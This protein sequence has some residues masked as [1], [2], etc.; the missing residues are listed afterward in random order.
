MYN[1]SGALVGS[2]TG[3]GNS[4]TVSLAGLAAGTYYVRVYGYLGATNPSYSLG[5]S[6]PAATTSPP[7]TTPTSPATSF[8]DV[9]YFGGSNDWNLNAI[10]APEAWAQG[11][12]G[13]GV[14]VAV[15]DTGV[16][17][18]NSD[19]AG[20]MWVNAGEI[21]GNGIDDDQNGFVDDT[22][23]WDFASGDNNPNDGNGHGTHVAGT[24]AA[25]NN[26]TG[27]TGVAPGATI[28]PV[29]V[30]GSNGSG[31][32]DAVAAGIRY[33]AA[34]GADIINLSLGGSFSSVIQSAIQY[35]QQLN[36]LV[37]VAAGN[38]SASTPSY[39]ARFSASMNNVIS[40]GAHTS[41]NTIAS[42]SNDVGSSGAVQVDAPGVN[43][44]STYIGGRYAT[45]SGTSMATPHV[46][47]LAAL[48]LSANH[49][50]TA[51]QLRTLIVDGA[52]R[53]ISGS[54]SNGGINAAVTVA[55]AASG[56]VSSSAAT[57]ATTQSL[58]GLEAIAARLF[59][60]LSIDG[61]DGT[62]PTANR[63][64]LA[65]FSPVGVASNHVQAPSAQPSEI[66]A[67]VR[68]RALLALDEA[69]DDD[70]GL[71]HI[72][73]GLD[74]WLDDALGGLAQ[75]DNCASDETIAPEDA[76]AAWLT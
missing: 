11:Y 72:D 32:A 31:T 75:H 25:D 8:P 64:A 50:L 12:T 26:G 74:G 65:A 14:V 60:R 1:A 58:S 41:S 46:A 15:V 17:S 19:L 42:F 52:N 22:S 20:R 59:G 28:M 44:Y 9:P 37:V 45:L 54:D 10:N 7:T 55:L 24:I 5:I 4:E 34:N 29:R 63:A 3:I 71:D 69:D 68:D 70:L 39:P 18:N 36:V 49:N 35:A 27:S 73:S 48:A 61:G 57:S 13:Q 56:Q 23:G 43:I 33:A 16:D 67:Y 38:E 66:A 62:Q 51:S 76:L 53:T 2:S 40:V 6:A 21:A 30:L 47:G